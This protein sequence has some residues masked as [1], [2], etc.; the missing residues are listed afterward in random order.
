MAGTESALWRHKQALTLRLRGVAFEL[1]K[2]RCGFGGNS[3]LKGVAFLNSVLFWFSLYSC[4]WR[5]RD[6]GQSL[7]GIIFYLKVWVLFCFLHTRPGPAALPLP[8]GR[9]VYVF[10]GEKSCFSGRP[11][12]H[13][14]AP[15]AGRKTSVLLYF[16]GHRKYSVGTGMPRWTARYQ[17][18][19]SR[20]YQESTVVTGS[21]KA[22]S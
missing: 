4:F 19:F 16:R 21:I 2:L 9:K 6:D 11:T 22:H 14:R 3:R 17:L 1:I 10:I 13:A 20:G 7:Q 18:F 15:P 8:V 5:Q 12:P